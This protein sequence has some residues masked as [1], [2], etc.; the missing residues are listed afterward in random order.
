MM[1]WEYLVVYVSE[2]TVNQDGHEYDVQ[3]YL[4]LVGQEGWE[5]VTAVPVAAD[6]SSDDEPAPTTFTCSLYL[7]REAGEADA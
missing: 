1:K 3:E 5:L 4:D 2:T 6:A 7:K